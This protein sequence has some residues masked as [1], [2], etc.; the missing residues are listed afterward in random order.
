MTRQQNDDEF[1][2]RIIDSIR[3]ERISDGPPNEVRRRVLALSDDVLTPAPRGRSV[4]ADWSRMAAIAATLLAV[5]DLGWGAYINLETPVSW[6]RDSDTD[7]WRV[8]YDSMRIETSTPPAG[9]RSH[10]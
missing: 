10:G 5:F 1:L 7:T 2:D 3:E 8:M 4:V 6:V 9:I